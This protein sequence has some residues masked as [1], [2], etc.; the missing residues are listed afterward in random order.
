MEILD[1]AVGH[2]DDRSKTY[3]SPDGERSVA[4]VVT[5]FNVLTGQAL[6]ETEGWLFLALLKIRRGHIAPGFHQDSWTDLAAYAGLA[7]E[8]RSRSAAE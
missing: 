5:A 1:A 2:I 3:D 7:G 4:A 6:T 8:A